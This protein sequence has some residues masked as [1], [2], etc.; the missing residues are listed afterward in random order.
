MNLNYGACLRVDHAVYR[1]DQPSDIIFLFV[2]R[3]FLILG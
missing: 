1:K 2:A 3:L